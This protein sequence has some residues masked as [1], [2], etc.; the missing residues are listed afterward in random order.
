MARVTQELNL[1][2]FHRSRHMIPLYFRKN[3]KFRDFLDLGNERLGNYR[4]AFGLHIG[5]HKREEAEWSRS[6]HFRRIFFEL[7]N[8]FFS[9]QSLKRKLPHCNLRTCG[10][11]RAEGRASCEAGTGNI[12]SL[13]CL[14]VR[15][16]Q[17]YA[18]QPDRYSTQESN[19]D[20]ATLAWGG[21]NQGWQRN[22]WSMGTN[23]YVTPCMRQLIKTCAM[24]D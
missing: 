17:Q 12:R 19:P 20:A 16:S 24:V 4:G 6:Y 9:D 13:P 23:A 22:F 3:F 8:M 2:D 7:P 11:T 10:T 15:R 5:Q 18:V 14:V 1:L 21:F